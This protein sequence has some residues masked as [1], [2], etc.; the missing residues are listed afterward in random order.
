MPG[1]SIFDVSSLEKRMDNF[2]GSFQ[3][4]FFEMPNNYVHSLHPWSKATGLFFKGK[5]DKMLG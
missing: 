3:F 5:S 1:T 2:S 4:Y